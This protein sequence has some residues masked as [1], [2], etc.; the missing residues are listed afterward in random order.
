MK[1]KT[2]HTYQYV[3]FNK[4]NYTFFSENA[5]LGLTNMDIE[6]LPKYNAVRIKNDKDD[7]LVFT[8]NVAYARPID[9]EAGSDLE[10]NRGKIKNNNPVV[11]P[12]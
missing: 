8:T 4:K 6:Y 9:A 7:I 12:R 11:A 1:L 10:E 3:I 5:S 2:L